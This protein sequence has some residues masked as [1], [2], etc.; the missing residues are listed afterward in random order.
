MYYSIPFDVVEPMLLKLVIEL[1]ELELEDINESAKNVTLSNYTRMV[2]REETDSRTNTVF[3]R[4]K[5]IIPEYFHS[6]IELS[7]SANVLHQRA[8]SNHEVHFDQIKGDL[9][10]H[11]YRLSMLIGHQKCIANLRMVCRDWDKILKPASLKLCSDGFVSGMRSDEMCDFKGSWNHDKPLHTVLRD[12]YIPFHMS[13]RRSLFSVDS[14]GDNFSCR[15]QAFPPCLMLSKLRCLRVTQNTE[16]VTHMGGLPTLR[17]IQATGKKK[18]IGQT[19]FAGDLTVKGITHGVMSLDDVISRARIPTR[20][21][22]AGLFF[23]DDVRTSTLL[24]TFKD[25][26]KCN[27]PSSLAPKAPTKSH[28]NPMFLTIDAELNDGR[29][30]RLFSTEKFYVISKKGV[31]RTWTAAQD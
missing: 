13:L 15:E 17:S 26:S 31:K 3:I 11:R 10:G 1:Q 29:T 4:D 27:F 6:F 30:M 24:I 25:T 5:N 14:S 28:H 12:K 18:D 23:K 8:L 7:Q 16:L 2:D 9:I 19:A 21:T 22:V 20:S